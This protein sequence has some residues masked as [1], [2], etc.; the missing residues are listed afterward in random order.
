MKSLAKAVQLSMSKKYGEVTLD[1]VVQM[2]LAS[3]G[4]LKD[5]RDE[6]ADV[7]I[8]LHDAEVAHNEK[9]ATLQAN[10]PADCGNDTKRRGWIR[11]NLA[12]EAKKLSEARREKI[13]ADRDLANAMDR[14]RMIEL[15]AGTT[16]V[17][18][19]KEGRH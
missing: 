3:F 4:E 13:W 6:M 15:L 1:D 10:V 18:N 2:I 14:V 5:V 8:D 11:T 16:D 17:Q 7:L 9:E 19:D 12:E